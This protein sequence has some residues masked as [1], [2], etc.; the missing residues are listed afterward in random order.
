[1]GCLTR[2]LGILLIGIVAGSV[3]LVAMDRVFFPWAFYFGGHP[4]WLPLWAGKAQVHRSDGDYVIYFFIQPTTAGSRMYNLPTFRGTGF[5]CTPRGQQYKLRAYAGMSE[6]TGTDTNGKT[7]SL[8]L[9]RRPWYWNFTGNWDHRPELQLRGTWQ[10]PNLVMDDG[11][12]FAAAFL[13]DGSL[14]KTPHSYY[15]S[16]SQDKQTIVFHEVTGW[17]QWWPDC[18][19]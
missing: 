13:P 15:H 17:Q 1:M 6:K 18:S 10:N 16:N 7:M 2:L 11:G 3:L 8:Q 12:S 5:I 14:G 19:P 4:H 9:Y